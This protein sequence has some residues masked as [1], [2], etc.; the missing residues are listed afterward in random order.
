MRALYDQAPILQRAPIIIP[1]IIR[2]SIITPIII[3]RY[4]VNH[5]SE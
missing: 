2:A 1:L 4:S 5:Y 3:L